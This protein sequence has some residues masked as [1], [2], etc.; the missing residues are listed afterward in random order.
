[1]LMLNNVNL[2]ESKE[3]QRKLKER[4]F[5]KR[6]QRQEIVTRAATAIL[7]AK[8]LA[9]LWLDGPLHHLLLFSFLHYFRDILT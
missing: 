6:L 4:T 5:C 2:K 7:A 8:N 3:T 9:I 1:M